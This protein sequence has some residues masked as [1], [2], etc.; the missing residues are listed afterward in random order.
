MPFNVTIGQQVGFTVAFFSSDVLTVPSSA[1]ITITYPLAANSLTLTSCTIGLSQ[2]GSFFTG[3]W[4]SS[5][6]A[7][8]LS[9]YVASAPGNAAP[10]SGSGTLRLSA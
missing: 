5:V 6:A 3:T 8:G 7:A 1:Q 9:S 2:S 10:S 4:A